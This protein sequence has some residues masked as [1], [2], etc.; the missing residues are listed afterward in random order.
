MN[1]PAQQSLLAHEG[2]EDALSADVAAL[3][4]AHRVG[5]KLRPE[6]TGKGA[7]GWLL[8][9]L[10]P[11]HDQNL[12]QSQIELI[13]QWARAAGSTNYAEYW[14]TTNNMSKPVKIEPEDEKAKLQREYIEAV[15]AFTALQSKLEKF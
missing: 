3:G 5:T 11:E 9:C 4:G 2:P 6:L 14:P 7:Q 1:N 10:N 15:K 12:K 8:N 13:V